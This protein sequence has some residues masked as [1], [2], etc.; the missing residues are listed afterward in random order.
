MQLCETRLSKHPDM[1]IWNNRGPTE[2]ITTS[3]LYMTHFMP[4]YAKKLEVLKVA[5]IFW[6]RKARQ[7]ISKTSRS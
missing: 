5:P 2:N 1:E 7:D 6:Y 3:E 4:H